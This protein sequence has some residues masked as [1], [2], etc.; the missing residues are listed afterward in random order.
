MDNIDINQFKWNG[1][2]S[3]PVPVKRVGP[4]KH[5]KG[6]KFLKGPIPMNWIEKAS[7]QSGH[8]LHVGMALWHLSGLNKSAKVKL[9][10]SVLRRMGVDRYAGYRGLQKLE[11]AG[12]VEV[13]R[14]KGRNP[15]VTILDASD[16][17]S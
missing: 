12:L 5:N 11:E 14:H 2:E 1:K 15:I 10:G 13:D 16:N 7:Q 3:F 4:P 6:E 9:S 8:A 17:P